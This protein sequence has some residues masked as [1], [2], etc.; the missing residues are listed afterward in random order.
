MDP[1]EPSGAG[2]IPLSLAGGKRK[3]DP[4]DFSSIA[5]GVVSLPLGIGI[6]SGSLRLFDP[7]RTDV[8]FLLLLRFSVADVPCLG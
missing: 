5:D 2:G 1:D 7:A 3:D 8:V 4:E 6:P